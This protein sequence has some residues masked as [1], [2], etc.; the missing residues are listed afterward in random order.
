MKKILFCIFF[1]HSIA[2]QTT[3]V[4]LDELKQTDNT[5]SI[6]EI[7]KETIKNSNSPVIL[8]FFATWCAPCR[9]LQPIVQKVHE[10]FG[11]SIIIINIDVDMYKALCHE[12]N[13]RHIP[14]LV[15]FKNGA[16]QRRTNSTGK[17]TIVK[18]IQQLL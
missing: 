3:M 18:V 4:N 11:D 1:V 16:E 12:Y 7:V 9:R 5:K 10:H 13:I 14:T 6:I 8:K 15:Y 17:D 2:I